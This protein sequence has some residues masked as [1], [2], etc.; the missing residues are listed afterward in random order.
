[1]K[2]VEDKE[3]LYALFH[4]NVSTGEKVRFDVGGEAVSKGE[5]EQRAMDCRIGQGRGSYVFNGWT[6]EAHPAEGKQCT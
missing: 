1:M 5:A 2:R 3:V 4:V 6:T